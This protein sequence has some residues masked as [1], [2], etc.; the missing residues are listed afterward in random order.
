MYDYSLSLVMIFIFVIKVLRIHPPKIESF[1]ANY[2]KALVITREA[3]K[4]NWNFYFVT[5]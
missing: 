5:G 4:G 2:L 1:V 3:A